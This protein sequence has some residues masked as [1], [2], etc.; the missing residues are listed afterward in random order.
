MSRYVSR[1]SSVARTHCA[2]TTRSKA[3]SAASKPDRETPGGR[4]SFIAPAPPRS[5]RWRGAEAH[6][7]AA[8]LGI[9]VLAVGLAHVLEDLVARATLVRPCEAP[10]LRQIDRIG[11]RDRILKFVGC[12]EPDALIDLHLIAVGHVAEANSVLDA[13]RV[14]DQCVPLPVTDGVSPETRL[15]VADRNLLLIEVD[16]AHLIVGL[17]DDGDLSRGLQ[18]LHGKHCHHHRGHAVRQAVCVVAVE[19]LPALVG[20]A[21]ASHSVLYS[22]LSGGSGAGVREV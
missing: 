2:P 12:E 19:R 1:S 3:P 14:H 9:L 17:L 11:D 16:A 15:G 22:G 21:R 4:M 5:M 7:C 10:G 13:D 6:A 8:V 20:F 18:H